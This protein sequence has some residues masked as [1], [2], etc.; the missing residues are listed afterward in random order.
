MGLSCPNQAAFPLSRLSEIPGPPLFFLAG[1]DHDQLWF[2][3]SGNNL[4][5]KVIGTTDR[6]VISNWY[7]GADN[8]VEEIRSGD[9]MTLMASE[10]ANL[11][12]AMAS[13][14]AP[15][16]GQTTLNAT[17]QAALEA[18]FVANWS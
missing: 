9:G 18:V 5:V 15:A 1:I 2:R 17:Q 3:Q 13:M 14:S 7:L 8:Q 4:E 10:V 6:V 12:S 11:V 16:A